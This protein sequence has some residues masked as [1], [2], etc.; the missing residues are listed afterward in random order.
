MSGSLSLSST[1]G[2]SFTL[3]PG[4][5]QQITLSPDLLHEFGLVALATVRIMRTILRGHSLSMEYNDITDQFS[6]DQTHARRSWS[7]R[8]IQFILSTEGAYIGCEPAV[9]PKTDFLSGRILIE[10]TR[11][12]ADLPHQI[13]GVG[14][15][16]SLQQNELSSPPELSRSYANT[17]TF[18]AA[19]L[20]HLLQKMHHGSFQ[21]EEQIALPPAAREEIFLYDP[22]IQYGK[23]GQLEF[24]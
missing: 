11:I 15:D 23:D 19:Q 8:Q 22:R 4:H 18:S 20:S 1:R 17:E 16:R 13:I 3:L 10:L 6:V 7:N 24:L 9:L 12:R 2:P 21:Q 14:V 5:E